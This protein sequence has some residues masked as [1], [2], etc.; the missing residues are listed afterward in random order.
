MDTTQPQHQF[1][2]LVAQQQALPPE[3]RKV[4]VYG[5]DF[6]ERFI[7]EL[8]VGHFQ[9]GIDR[10]NPRMSEALEIY[11]N[12]SLAGHRRKFRLDA[13][14]SLRR[15][16]Y[17]IGDLRLSDLRHH[18]I[19]D[20]RDYLLAQNLSP[21]T[22]RK[23][24]SILNAMLNAAFK[25]Y[26]ID[27]P[28]PFRGLKIRGEGEVTRPMRTITPELL[29]QVKARLM[30]AM[31]PYSLVGLLQLNTGLR[32]SEPI[33]AELA[34]CCLD[35]AIPHLWVRRNPLSDRK[36]KSS[37]RAVPLVGV[38][39]FAAQRLVEQARQQE[40]QWLVPHYAY[41][42]GSNSC[43]AIMNKR[44]KDL[45]F[46]SHMFR[47][48]LVDRMKACNDIPVKVA[49]SITGHSRGNSEYASYG[50][51]G[52]TLAQKLEVLTRVAV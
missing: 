33:Y 46:R 51:V 7:A 12:E 32:L 37:I 41:Q 2:D 1:F 36:T 4:R 34:D 47:H 42:G 5:V 27:R 23:Q 52:Y 22:V 20:F 24:A 35:H 25:F 10:D 3:D 14:N 8:V 43:S 11:I 19:C 48:A 39:L 28:S 17:R 21:T 13:E 15:F 44:L 6:D 31:N 29:R 45:E 38:S 9:N 49:E 50:T 18:H 30:G 16:F 40:S 26:A